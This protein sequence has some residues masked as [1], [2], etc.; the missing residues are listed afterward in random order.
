MFTC[1]KKVHATGWMT[2]KSEL[3]SQQGQEVFLFSEENKFALGPFHTHI[4]W[5]AV[6]LFRA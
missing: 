2:E 5:L 1:L 3:E 4:E 6:A